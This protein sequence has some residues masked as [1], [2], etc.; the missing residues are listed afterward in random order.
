M[1]K[2]FMNVIKGFFAIFIKG[3]EE[4][5]PEALIEQKKED[6]RNSV[7]KYNE[8]LA[9]AAAFIERLKRNIKKDQQKEQELSARIKAFMA[10]GNNQAAGQYAIQYKE[11]KARM[12]ENTQQLQLAEANYE[13]LERS[14]DTAIRTA[15]QQL[16]RYQNTLSETKM[17]EAQAELQE[18]AKKLTDSFNSSLNFDHLGEAIEA[19]RDKALGKARV[20]GGLLE[21]NSNT[22]ADQA[23]MNAEGDAALAEFMAMSDAQ[24]VTPIL[25]DSVEANPE[26]AQRN[27][28]P[29]MRE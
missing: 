12:S 8:N 16:M 18:E 10:A 23:V 11:L 2:R 4:R 13:K 20:A 26:M 15:E 17:L 29:M 25:P 27:M 14:R 24:P 28:G 19:R 9:N 7:S 5:N 6:L 21:D 22:L 3:F 1:F